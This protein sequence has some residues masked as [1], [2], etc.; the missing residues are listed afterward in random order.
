MTGTPV[1]DAGST[2][3]FGLAGTNSTDGRQAIPFFDPQ[4]AALPRIRPREADLPAGASDQAAH[5]VALEP[6]DERRVRPA[7]RTDA[8]ALARVPSGRTALRSAHA[9]ARCD[10]DSAPGRACSCWSIRSTSRRTRFAIDQ[11]ALAGGHIIAFVD[12]LAES[13]VTPGS[14]PAPGGT[15]LD[16]LLASWGV[17]FNP[18]RGHRRPFAR[19]QCRRRRRQR[20]ASIR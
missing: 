6:A 7:E 18:Q 13:A 15:G 19:A 14:P 20:P 2:L 3:Y 4:Q 8:P 9:E 17:R 11:Y 12:P 1:N 10:G 16:R 5:R